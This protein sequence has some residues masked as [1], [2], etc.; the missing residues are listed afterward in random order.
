MLNTSWLPPGIGRP[1]KNHWSTGGGPPRTK[2]ESTRN[3]PRRG[4][5][6]VGPLRNSGAAPTNRTTA[7]SLVVIPTALLATSR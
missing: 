7:T 3:S 2:Q 4:L 6:L 1:S 5:L